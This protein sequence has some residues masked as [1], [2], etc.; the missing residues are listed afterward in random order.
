MSKYIKEVT[1]YKCDAEG[2]NEES[3]HPMLVC[4]ICKG[5]MCKNHGIRANNTLSIECYY[6]DIKTRQHQMFMCDSCEYLV[7]ENFKTKQMQA[8]INGAIHKCLT[9]LLPFKTKEDE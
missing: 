9:D 4:D 8:Y 3:M 7:L 5:D 1:I 6:G 2:C